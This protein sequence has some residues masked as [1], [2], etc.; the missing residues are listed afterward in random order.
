[1]LND[2]NRNLELI[3]GMETDY[4]KLL[5]YDLP[6]MSC[7]YKSYEYP[8]LC[9]IIEGC[10]HVSVNSDT[11]FTYKPGQFILLPPYS[12]VH[13][14]IDVPTKALVFELNDNLLKDVIDKISIDMDTDCDTFKEDNFF[15]AILTAN[16]ADA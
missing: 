9:T 5:Y 6:T 14:D 8:R 15:S 16:L 2:F 10:K 7:D 3:D 13:M 4:I 11:K 1:M 12:N